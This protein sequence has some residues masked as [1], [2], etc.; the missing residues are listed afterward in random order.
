MSIYNH[1]DIHYQKIIADCWPNPDKLYIFSDLSHFFPNHLWLFQRLNPSVHSVKM[2]V[3]NKCVLGFYSE[4]DR[5]IFSNWIHSYYSKFSMQEIYFPGPFD[6]IYPFVSNSL[7][8]TDSQFGSDPAP[9]GAERDAWVWVL[10]NCSD[11]VRVCGGYYFFK[12]EED[13]I[14]FDLKFYNTQPNNVPF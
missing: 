5:Y 9:N 11:E 3:D 12:T 6:G 14:M 10:G 8:R 7:V 1:D 4:N 2:H 13:R